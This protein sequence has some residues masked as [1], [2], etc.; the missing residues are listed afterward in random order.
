MGNDV[1][2]NKIETIERCV[3]RI[4]EVYDYNPENLN[5]YTKQDY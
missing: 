2:Y 3:N 4:N 1:I 5:D